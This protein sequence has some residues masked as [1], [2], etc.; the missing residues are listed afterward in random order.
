MRPPLACR[1]TFHVKHSEAPIDD[2]TLARLRSFAALVRKWNSKVNL[3]ARADLEC[4][5]PRHIDDSA[6]LA[7]L[8]PPGSGRFVDL[9][10]GAGFPGLVLAIVTNAH[11]D[12]IESDQRKAAFL[13]EAARLTDA[14][15][16]VHPLRAELARV[17][18]A[19]VLTARALA[20]LPRLLELAERFLTKDGVCLFP[21][22]GTVDAELTAAAQGW[23]MRVERFA[24][25]TAPGATILRLSEIHRAGQP[26]RQ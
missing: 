10:S 7:P 26:P 16:T 22:G 17:Q 18:P 8:F 23:H 15:A 19:N 21:K 6:Q 24:S 3:V 5:W 12:L 11:V 25:K 1:L 4:L 13:R 14:P 9:G 2:A 20:P